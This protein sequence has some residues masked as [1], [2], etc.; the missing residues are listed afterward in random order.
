VIAASGSPASAYK[1]WIAGT[2]EPAGELLV[3]EGAA[4]ALG[5]GRSLLPTGVTGVSGTFDR[6]AALRVRD[7]GG[8]EIARGL[9][10]Y[11]AAE[12]RA[13]LGLSSVHIADA[14]GYAG[15]DELIH[16]DDLVLL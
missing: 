15:P 9:V 2:L 6:G 13:I 10:A 16:R 7:A 3:D 4:T 11:S 8:R 12:A 14:L 1:S 5:R